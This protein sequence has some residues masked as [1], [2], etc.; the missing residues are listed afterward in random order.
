M[1][2]PA[3]PSKTRRAWQMATEFRRLSPTVLELAG[4][5]EFEGVSGL[6]DEQVDDLFRNALTIEA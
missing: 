3:T 2:D 5:L 4:T 1:V 6:T